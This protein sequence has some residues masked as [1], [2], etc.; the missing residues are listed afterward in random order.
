MSV[1]LCTNNDINK[2]IDELFSEGIMSPCISV[3]NS[4][5]NEQ[6]LKE[7]DNQTCRIKLDGTWKNITFKKNNS[8]LFLEVT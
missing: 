1:R 7:L 2:W 5:M 8:S 4:L 3:R 6:M